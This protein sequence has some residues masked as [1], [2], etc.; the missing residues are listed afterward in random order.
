MEGGDEGQPAAARGQHLAGQQSADRVGNGVVDMQ[1]VKLMEF[2]N[3]GH[4]RGQRQV[5]GRELEERIAGDGNLVV[6]DAVVASAEPEGLRVGDE[7][8]FV[9]EGG[10]FDAQFRGHDA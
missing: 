4:A 9:A 6:V 10:Q 7:M 2:S 3:L 8:H 5:V 1:Q